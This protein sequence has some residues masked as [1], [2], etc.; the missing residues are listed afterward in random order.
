[1]T[2]AVDVLFDRGT[3]AWVFAL[4]T[5]HGHLWLLGR[6]V[7]SHARQLANLDARVNEAHE[8]LSA[9]QS[10]ADALHTEYELARLLHTE[11]RR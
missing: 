7:A 5:L 9:L 4:L 3:W 1:M 11:V 10:D 6:R 2:D 8:A